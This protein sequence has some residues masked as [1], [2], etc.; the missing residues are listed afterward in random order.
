MSSEN[1]YKSIEAQRAKAAF[2][3]DEEIGPGLWCVMTLKRILHSTQ[4]EYQKIDVIETYF[5]KT[6]VTDGKTQSAQHD[7]FAY[8]ESLVHPAM[9]KSM[10]A[11]SEADDYFPDVPPASVFIGGGGELATAREVLRHRSVR[12]VVMVD[13]DK[14][15][16]N[17]CR[18]YLPE[19]GGDEVANDRRLE[20]IVGDALLYLDNTEEKF[21]VIIMDISDPIEAGPGILLYTKEFYQLALTRL[22]MP[23]GVFV[24]QTGTADSV[25]PPHVSK[26]ITC[27]GPIYNTLKSVFDC[28][29][30]Y[31]ILIPRRVM[32]RAVD[33]RARG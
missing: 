31:S 3:F 18:K 7:E 20:L 8:H 21:D 23:H 27:Y 5:G 11:L 17:V 6:L 14:E 25:P 19:W 30:P 22:N 26:D 13:V 2:H 29:V 16:I 28:V 15:I 33:D 4:S 24:T 9:F 12:R 1:N 32:I 10:T